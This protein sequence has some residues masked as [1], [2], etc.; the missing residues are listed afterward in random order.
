MCNSLVVSQTFRLM[1]S[2]DLKSKMHLNYWMS[3]ILG[4]LLDGPGGHC[5]AANNYE[6]EHYNSVAERIIM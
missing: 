6:S 1:K 5:V 3:D 4:N 2:S